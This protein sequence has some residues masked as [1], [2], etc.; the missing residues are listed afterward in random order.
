MRIVLLAGRLVTM[1]LW[2][3]RASPSFAQTDEIQVYDAVIAPTGAFNL[4]LHDNYTLSS[5]TAPRFAG[6]IVPDKSL[7][8]AAEWAYG[9][10]PWGESTFPR[11]RSRAAASLLTMGIETLAILIATPLGQTLAVTVGRLFCRQRKRSRNTKFPQCF[12]LAWVRHV[13]VDRDVL[14]NDASGRT[15]NNGFYVQFIPSIK[16]ALSIY[17]LSR[18]ARHVTPQSPSLIS[19]QRPRFARRIEWDSGCGRLRR[20]PHAAISGG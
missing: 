6:G 19:R 14:R 1:L 18:L 20:A 4:T 11:I 7:N 8:G 13:A 9:K 12:V 16:D 10:A 3:G 5:D 15:C 17:A 2:L